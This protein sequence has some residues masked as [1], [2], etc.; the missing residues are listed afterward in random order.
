MRGGGGIER[1]FQLAPDCRSIDEVRARLTA[2]GY[3]NVRAH[4]S[5]AAAKQ[6]GQLL[7]KSR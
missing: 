6:L 4:I 1:A 5:G 2:E 7:D 3:E